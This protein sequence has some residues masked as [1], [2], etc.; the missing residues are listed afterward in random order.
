MQIPH[1][2][3]DVHILAV[4]SSANSAESGS[5]PFCLLLQ[6]YIYIKKN[7]IHLILQQKKLL[8]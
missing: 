4:C 8:L 1:T 3:E 7:E 6:R 2:K 5:F